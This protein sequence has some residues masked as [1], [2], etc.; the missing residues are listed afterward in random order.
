MIIL[1]EEGDL[2]SI[3]GKKFD[4]VVNFRFLRWWLTDNSEINLGEYLHGLQCYEPVRSGSSWKNEKLTKW[5]NFLPVI[6][7][8]S[9]SSYHILLVLPILW[10]AMSYLFIV[11]THSFK[12]LR[13]Q[14]HELNIMPATKW[15]ARWT[16]SSTV[17][18]SMFISPR[19]S[20]K[21]SGSLMRFRRW[22]L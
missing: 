4:H 12:W 1:Y 9:P 3:T 18:K 5:S 6:E 14:T 20:T 11:F 10:S 15:S 2:N 13:L 19:H 22:Q 7:F 21:S 16:S 8:R 17:S